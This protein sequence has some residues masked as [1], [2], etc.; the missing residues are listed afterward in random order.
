M[1]LPTLRAQS[2]RL[3][4]RSAS[5][6]LKYE[7]LAVGVPKETFPLEKRCAASPTS[8][9]LLKKNGIGEV[10]IEDGA[11]IGASY[12]NAA[13]EAAGAKI[14]SA[15]EAY[16]ADVVLK[17]R[18]PSLEEAS[19]LKPKNTLISFIQPGQNEDLVKTLAKD[20]HTVL[21]MDCIPRTL[22]RGQ[23]YD[24]LSSQAN[25]AGYR[26]VIEA[27]NEFGRFFA[28]QMTAAGK[29]RS[30]RPAVLRCLHAIDATRVH[31]TRSWVAYFSSLRPFGPSRETMTLRAGAARQSLGAWRWRRRLSRDPDGEEHGRHRAGFRR[32]SRRGRT[33]RSDGRA[34]PQ[35]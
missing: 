8:V 10:L 29:V 20:N 9:A 19:T 35:S 17:L 30:R 6:G 23:T 27:S 16:N 5:T 4:R 24:A 18:P 28:G 34:V 22:S 32:E 13:Y 14:V 33:D 25:I 11:G 15:Q 31:Q 26:A 21:A 12:S 2:L 1:Y 3:A 7:A